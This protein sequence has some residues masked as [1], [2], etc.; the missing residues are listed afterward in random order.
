MTELQKFVL[1]KT[2]E[3]KDFIVN[4]RF[5]R[6]KY[7]L[8]SLTEC[9]EQLHELSRRQL[10]YFH[11]VESETHAYPAVVDHPNRAGKCKAAGFTEG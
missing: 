4:I 8:S 1:E 7:R 9:R 6:D 3:R 5:L 11:R 10:V 2:L